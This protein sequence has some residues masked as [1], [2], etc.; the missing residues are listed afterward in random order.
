VSLALSTG[1]VDVTYALGPVPVPVPG[2]LALQDGKLA[3]KFVAAPLRQV[4]EEVSRRSGAQVRWLGHQAEERLISVEFTALPLPEALGRIL[5]RTNFLLFYTAVGEGIKL[6]QIWIFAQDTDGEQSGL[7][8]Q[9]SAVEEDAEPDAIP[10]DTLI[11]TAVSRA[12]PAV[13]IDAIARLGEYAQQDP[14]VEGI[15][16]HLAANDGSPQVQAAASEVLRGTN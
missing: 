13:R 15:L 6:T 4:I 1:P 8:R 16:S 10:I 14:R 5:G 11:Q 7:T 9:P 3:A 2:Q 12:E